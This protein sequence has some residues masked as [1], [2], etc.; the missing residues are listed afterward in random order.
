MKSNAILLVLIPIF[1]LNFGYVYGGSNASTAKK[2]GITIEGFIVDTEGNGLAGVEVIIPSKGVS[3]NSSKSGRFVIEL[4]SGGT[5]HLE[6]FKSGFLPVSTKPIKLDDNIAPLPL[7]ITL[8]KSPLEE[9]VVTGTH[10]PKLYTE[11]AIKTA[12]ASKLEIEKKGAV[13]L[14]DSLEMMTG[15]RVE[16]N[17]QNC[18]F[19]QVRIN[20]MEG[21][22]SQILID[23]MPVVSALAGVYALEQLPSNMIDKLEVV[24]GGGS[25]L[26]GGNAVAGVVNVITKEPQKSGTQISLTQESINK[27]P[28]TVLSFNTDYVSK[29]HA[30]SASFFTNYQ[31]RDHMDY[32]DDDFSD[33]GELTNL[34]LGSNFAHNFN[35]INGKLKLNFASIFE[36]RRGGNKFDLPEHFA[37]IAESI[38]TYRTDFGIGWEQTFNEKSFLRINGSFSYTKRKSYYGA[39]QDPNAY[40]Q[41][42]N[43]VFYGSL[44]YSNFALNNHSFVAGFSYKSDSIE[45]QAPAY[46]RI[47]DE[48][49]TDFGI[50]FQD[51]IELF[52]NSSTLLVGIRADKH[53]EIENVIFSPRASFLYKGVKNLTFRATY[54]SGFRAPQVFDEDLHITQVGGEGML[55]TNRGG[56]KEER[57][58]SITVGVD[59]G[60]QVLNTLYQFTFS[61]FYNH[62]DNVFTLE[63]TDTEIDNARVFERFN[64]DG[65]TIYGIEVEAGFKRV[66]RFEI[67][68]GWTFQKSE[69][70]EPEP[71]FNSKKFFRSPDLYG[72][73]RVD[74]TIPKF[75]NVRMEMNYTGSMKVPHYAGYIAEDVLEES[76]PFTV[77]NL[78]ISKRISLN[79]KNITLIASIFNIFDEYQDDL[80]RGIFRDA[81][82]VYGPRMPRSFRLGLKYNF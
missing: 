66:D 24:K 4:K 11:T 53:S 44:T 9:I 75:V 63:E 20:G 74:W 48:L 52:E 28:N 56:L 76:D 26:Y 34:S 33:L 58:H 8:H 13:S 30:T 60:L 27:S 69:L 42:T 79:G 25:A 21:K 14:A 82:Y 40:G 49:Y 59:Y 10:T 51:E 23:G 2:V 46:N 57:S 78:S 35:N 81:G 37:D 61:G 19:N 32:N 39:E 55:I 45:D 18:N 50:F 29:S 65:A 36:D 17:C 67:F 47:L 43:P 54:S 72:S 5:I 41:T 7:S 1:I 80:D 12:V 64:S 73:V 38:R 71:D 68:T 16:N 3:V 31:K 77:F 15:V 62:L 6:L 22:Y 70:E